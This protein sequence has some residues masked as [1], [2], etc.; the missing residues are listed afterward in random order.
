MRLQASGDRL[1]PVL[2]DDTSGLNGVDKQFKVS[3]YL[4]SH[5]CKLKRNRK[6]AVGSEITRQISKIEM[7]FKG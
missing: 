4:N 2:V 7:F 6:R 3:R 1:L 5:Q